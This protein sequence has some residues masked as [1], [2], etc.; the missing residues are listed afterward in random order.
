[1]RV[2]L[3]GAGE[4]P[5]EEEGH[6]PRLLVRVLK[7]AAWTAIT[8][9]VALLSLLG[10]LFLHFSPLPWAALRDVLA[11]AFVLAVIGGF[12]LLKPRVKALGLFAVLFGAVFLWFHFIPASND[13]NWQ[14]DVARTAHAEIE[15]DRLV[16]HNVRDFRYRSESDYD[17]HWETRTYDLSKLSNLDMLFSYW[18]PKDI[19]HTM[20]CFGFEG[21]QYLCISVETRKTIGETYSP[22]SSFFKQFELIYIFGDERD[23]VALRTNHRHEDTYLFPRPLPPDKI[24]FLLLDIIASANR[25]HT[26]PDFYRTIRDNCTTALIGH[27]RKVQP[28]KLGWTEIFNGLIPRRAYEQGNIPNDAPYEEVMRRFAISAKALAC[29]DG[30]DFSQCIRAGLGAPVS[31]ATGPGG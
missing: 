4:M 14:P 21:G 27:V 10:T 9:I 16:L 23:L 1:L 28:V 26:H 29:G 8:P 15:G 12:L 20:L 30:P 11:G 31:G 18:G 3:S 17:Q 22:V 25:L 24:R 2:G 19:A 5:V 6:K 7:I 13:R